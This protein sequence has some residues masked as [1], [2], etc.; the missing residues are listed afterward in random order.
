MLV[1]L[2]LL[3]A[4]TGRPRLIPIR[5]ITTYGG[6]ACKRSG[7]KPEKHGIIVE[8]G[9]KAKRLDGEPKLGF[10]TVR[11]V[12]DADGEQLARESRINYSKLVTVEHNVKVFFIGSIYRDD[13]D[14]VIDAVNKCWEDKIYNRYK[15]M[16]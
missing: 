13:Y 5:F 7:I 8:K 3:D 16:A 12:I 6:K 15:S 1:K 14:L 11:M 10:P 9:A 4:G 2:F